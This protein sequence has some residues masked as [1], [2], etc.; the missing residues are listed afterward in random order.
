MINENEARIL[1][2]GFRIYNDDGSSDVYDIIPPSPS[3]NHRGGIIAGTK[4][5][6]D[7][8]EIKIGEDGKGYVPTYPV[9]I[10]AL[11]KTNVEEYTPTEDYHPATKK[12][13]DDTVNDSIN[14]LEPCSW[15]EVTDKPFGE[16]ITNYE[17]IFENVEMTSATQSVEGLNTDSSWNVFKFPMKVIYNN[18]E[19]IITQPLDGQDVCGDSNLSEYPFS[20]EPANSIYWGIKTANIGDVISMYI[21]NTEINPIDEKYIPDTIQ[22][23]SSVLTQAN[24][25]SASG[26]YSPTEDTDLTTK[27]Y[28]DDSIEAIP[29]DVFI[30]TISDNDYETGYDLVRKTNGDNVT[31]GVSDVFEAYDSCKHLVVFFYTERLHL[32]S[33]SSN[34]LIFTDVDH[35]DHSVISTYFTFYR[36]TGDIIK[37]TR[38]INGIIT[39]EDKYSGLTTTDKTIIGAINELNSDLEDKQNKNLIV[40]ITSTTDDE[41]T[42]TYTA[43]KTITEIYEAY[44]NGKPIYLVYNNGIYNLTNITSSSA[45]FFRH[46]NANYEFFTITSSKII[47]N[48]DYLQK[49]SDSSLTTEDTSIVGAINEVNTHVTDAES[50]LEVLEQTQPDWSQNDETAKDYV[51]NRVCYTKEPITVTILDEQ[52]LELTYDETYGDYSAANVA[53]ISDENIEYFRKADTLNVLWNDVEYE[54]PYYY[55]YNNKGA[56]MIG[57]DTYVKYPFILYVLDNV[58]SVYTKDSAVKTK[59]TINYVETVQLDEKYIS[60]KPGLKVEGKIFTIDDTEVLASKGA[61]IFNDY[62]NNIATGE[63]GHSEGYNTKA[64]GSYQHVQ[65]KYNIEDTENKYAHI[66]GNGTYSNRSNAHTVDWNGNAEYQGDIIAN[67]CGGENPISL[68]NVYNKLVELITLLTVS[69]EDNGKTL[70]VVNG[71]WIKTYYPTAEEIADIVMS[72][73]VET[74]DSINGE[75]VYNIDILSNDLDMINGEVI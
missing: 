22:R 48:G 68:V 40:T 10:D 49:T 44:S 7:T 17:L 69:E 5:E 6:D 70:Q 13:V 47:Y 14:S 73:Y 9:I 74:I 38:S 54:L 30:F 53:T 18:T 39:E 50:R 72:K 65:G 37:T 59:I 23:T 19:Y 42:V 8:V 31:I 58:F 4:T 55:S 28:V 66:V 20:I 43:D 1:S 24:T 34:S 27:G 52:E 61:E 32:A 45:L 64:T 25:N 16:E 3:L 71:A 21:A 29:S 75:T 46:Q 51:N 12:Y 62:D 36:N 26:S 41:G 35:A 56:M 67:A 11:S 63:Y 2:D 15:S 60:Y 33:Y 57:D